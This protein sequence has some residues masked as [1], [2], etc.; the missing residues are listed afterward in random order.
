MKPL[1]IN[2]P[3]QKDYIQNILRQG[4]D[5]EFW[6]VICLRLKDSIEALQSQ[7]DSSELE[8]L[9]SEEYKVRSEVMRKQ[10]IDREDMLD[11]PK[12]LIREL[13]NPEFFARKREEEVYADAEDF[14]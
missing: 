14:E 5:S 10:K 6:K 13:D 11:M 2:D 9:I 12:D 1:N 3:E 8:N 7:R 4:K